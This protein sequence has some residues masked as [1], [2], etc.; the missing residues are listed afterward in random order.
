MIMSTANFSS[1]NISF[2]EITN[3]LAK[4]S[5]QACGRLAGLLDDGETTP[6]NDVIIDALNAM[7]TP[8]VV[9]LMKTTSPE[10]VSNMFQIAMNEW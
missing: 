9:S 2:Q 4:L 8:Y 6:R 3:Q 5:L 7:L 10:E 1:S